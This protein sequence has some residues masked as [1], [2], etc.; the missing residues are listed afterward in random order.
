MGRK[1]VICKLIVFSESVATCC[2]CYLQ[3]FKRLLEIATFLCEKKEVKEKTW[4]KLSATCLCELIVLFLLKTYQT[5]TRNVL[6]SLLSKI[7]TWGF[8]LTK[9]EILK[10]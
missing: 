7:K 3:I 2:T 9:F 10:Y 5:A 1:P 8:V 4:I 6:S